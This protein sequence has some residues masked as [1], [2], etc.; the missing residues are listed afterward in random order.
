VG[1]VRPGSCM[2]CQDNVLLSVSRDTVCCYPELTIGKMSANRVALD[3]ALLLVSVKRTADG[4]PVR[5]VSVFL[6]KCVEVVPNARKYAQR[7][8][9]C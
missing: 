7:S 8:S 2:R 3:N 5:T 4:K 1:V 6:P 9:R